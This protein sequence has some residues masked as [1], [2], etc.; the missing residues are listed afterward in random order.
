[1]LVRQGSRCF[2]AQAMFKISPSVVV[3]VALLMSSVGWMIV[4]S[5][6]LVVLVC[7]V[8]MVA[9]WSRSDLVGWVLLLTFATSVV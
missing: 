7:S 8:S 5:G 2:L 9:A 4:M 3:S 1:M 6:G